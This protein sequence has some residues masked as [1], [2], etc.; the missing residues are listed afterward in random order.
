[1]GL[2]EGLRERKEGGMGV[3]RYERGRKVYG[4]PGE[5]NHLFLPYQ[6]TQNPTSP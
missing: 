1:M 4:A 6:L 3:G 5:C 2:R